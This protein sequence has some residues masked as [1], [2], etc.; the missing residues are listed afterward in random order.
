MVQIEIACFYKT[1]QRERKETQKSN[2]S[3]KAN[4]NADRLAVNQPAECQRRKSRSPGR[5][6]HIRLCPCGLRGTL[7]R[8]L[9][10]RKSEC[11][12]AGPVS[13]GKDGRALAPAPV[14]APPGEPAGVR[15]REV[16]L[17]ARGGGCRRRGGP[18]PGSGPASEAAPSSRDSANAATPRHKAS[19]HTEV[20]GHSR[21]SHGEIGDKSTE[22]ERSSFS[23]IPVSRPHA[24][25]PLTLATRAPAWEFPW[26]PVSSDPLWLFPSN[27]RQNPSVSAPPPS[28]LF[29]WVRP[30]RTAPG[31]FGRVRGR[32]PS[33][34]EFQVLPRAP[35]DR[36]RGRL[37]PRAA[38]C[39]PRDHPAP[40][41]SGLM[42]MPCVPPHRGRGW[43]SPCT[44]S[45]GPAALVRRRPRSRPARRAAVSSAPG[46]RASAAS[47]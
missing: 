45:L 16:A 13:G 26:V 6:G 40:E 44:Q 22:T 28:T 5:R 37:G 20:T 18:A 2:V 38:S 24:R 25:T 8:S 23:G 35:W 34:S 46:L 42:E 47:G 31:G 41:D 3:H 21:F 17:G 9:I 10:T 29:L 43:G 12:R 30:G 32:G 1:M 27:R 15:P 7:T 19:L 14:P 36:G 4:K 33:I 39:D 11:A